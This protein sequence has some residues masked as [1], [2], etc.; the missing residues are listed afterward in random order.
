ML[1]EKEIEHL[2]YVYSALWEASNNPIYNA[3]LKVI[4]VILADELPPGLTSEDLEEL[5]AKFRKEQVSIRF[6][7]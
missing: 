6:P 2:R 1:T 5:I 3:F 7:I 4:E